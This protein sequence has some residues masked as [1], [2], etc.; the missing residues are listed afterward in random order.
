MIDFKIFSHILY[1]RIGNGVPVEDFVQQLFFNIA[2]ID[3]ENTVIDKDR[4]TFYRYYTGDISIKKMAQEIRPFIYKSR[5]QDYLIEACN[6]DVV[7]L[8][9]AD[10]SSYGYIMDA[11]D[12][13]E[14]ISDIFVEIL[15]SKVKSNKASVQPIVNNFIVDGA[16]N[17]QEIQSIPLNELNQL[18]ARRL[19][20]SMNIANL[21]ASNKLPDELKPFY[22]VELKNAGDGFR[23]MLVPKTAEADN[24]YPIKFEIKFSSHNN[25]IDKIKDIQSLQ[26]EA[27]RTNRPVEIGHPLSIKEMVGDCIN[28]LPF[29]P[30]DNVTSS[31]VYLGP[32]NNPT[33]IMVDIYIYNGFASFKLESVI[34]QRLEERD[35]FCRFSNLRNK[36]DWFDFELEVDHS[37]LSIHLSPRE[38]TP[39]SVDKY[40]EM[41]KYWVL[42]ADSSATIR[43]SIHETKKLLFEATNCGTKTYS[44]KDIIKI[45]DIIDHL[46]R[47]V[48]IEDRIGVIFDFNYD[49]F[50][51]NLF[52]VDLLY[53]AMLKRTKLLK[54]TS[55]WTFESKGQLES[56]LRVGSKMN[57]TSE[58]SY[59]DVLG[60]RVQINDMQVSLID[61]LIDSISVS[62]DGYKIHCSTNS[63]KIEP[64]RQ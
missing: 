64:I 52:A 56:T 15:A 12:F 29:M 31:T 38:N 10:F 45:Q 33:T 36:K 14:K 7:P 48:Q 9:V 41:Y 13:H 51:K 5:F 3:S 24:R 28:P 17:P 37:S 57:I 2:E 47:L 21:I 58:L 55:H 22:N 53:Y 39:L 35:G 8:L 61:A 20:E 6:E 43:L 46:E 1:D 27:N 54:K 25:D 34:I 42:V 32:I 40:L 11:F 63:L 49:E 50:S 60:K 59:I 62:E 44:Q 4:T 19:N 16:L 23:Y 26:N 30:Y 18:S